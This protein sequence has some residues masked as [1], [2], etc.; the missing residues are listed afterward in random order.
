MQDSTSGI[1][2]AGDLHVHQQTD[3]RVDELFESPV[4]SFVSA[5]SEATSDEYI[6]TI[7]LGLSK[8]AQPEIEIGAFLPEDSDVKMLEVKYE[9]ASLRLGEE[10]GSGRRYLKAKFQPMYPSRESELS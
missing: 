7:N 3:P 2:V 10:V 8:V 9:G 5:R 1:Q 6:L 4:L